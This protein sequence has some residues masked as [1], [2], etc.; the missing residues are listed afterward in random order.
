MELFPDLDQLTI[1]REDYLQ[2]NASLSKPID[3]NTFLRANAFYSKYDFELYS[4]FT[5][6]LEDPINGDQ[7]RQKENRSIY[8]M[9]AELNKKVKSNDW[10]ALFQ[11]GVGFRADATIDTELSHTLNRSITLENIKLGDIDETNAFTYLN[12]EIKLGKLL[13]NPAV[14]LD[15]FKFNYRDKLVPIYKTQ[16][17]SEVKISP[18]L[19][20][21][22]SQNNLQFF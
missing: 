6:F 9:N 4:N 3:E 1:Q 2:N 10:D 16:T 15:Y 7:I 5:F 20:F 8:G 17:E 22:Y 19:N 21:I 11:L 12:T 14:R 13:I 18:K